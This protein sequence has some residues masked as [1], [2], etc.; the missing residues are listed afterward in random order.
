MS[1][2]GLPAS[3]RPRRP[4]ETYSRATAS[5]V[6]NKELS[7]IGDDM[8]V[9]AKSATDEQLGDSDLIRATM[10]RI[11]GAHIGKRDVVEEMQVVVLRERAQREV[12]EQKKIATRLSIGFSHGRS[13]LI[14]TDN[15]H[16][17][18]A[19]HEFDSGA[20]VVHVVDEDGMTL[21]YNRDHLV[22]IFKMK[23]TPSQ[24]NQDG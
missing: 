22:L 15:Y 9:W 3:H 13:D 8:Q 14:H 5:E 12:D 17:E 10:G 24:E 2:H 6:S 4:S 1:D 23:Q 21:H 20:K 7:E 18:V 11:A 16:A 19:I